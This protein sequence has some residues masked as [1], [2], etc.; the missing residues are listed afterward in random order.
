MTDTQGYT[1]V[2]GQPDKLLIGAL[3]FYF[4]NKIQISKV[5]DHVLSS[6][7]WWIC[8]MF[9]APRPTLLLFT[10]FYLLT[11]YYYYYYFVI[12]H[13]YLVESP[14]SVLI[15]DPPTSLFV[16]I[17]GLFNRSSRSYIQ[18]TFSASRDVDWILKSI[19]LNRCL[20]DNW[21]SQ[22]W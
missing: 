21:S 12:K 8:M 9:C 16:G 5:H 3:I 15:I 13:I 14:L 11:Y 19:A 1:H 6:R 17:V 18:N 7:P 20:Q 22:R 10:D 2:R 4:Q